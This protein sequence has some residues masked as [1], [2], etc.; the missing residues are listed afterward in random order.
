DEEKRFYSVR[1]FAWNLSQPGKRPDCVCVVRRHSLVVRGIELP[2][3][4]TE[5]VYRTYKKQQQSTDENRRLLKQTEAYF[6]QKISLLSGAKICS[7]NPIR[8]EQGIENTVLCEISAGQARELL[9]E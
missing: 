2:L 3:G 9:L 4:Y 8:T 5:Y 6:L 7:Q 1:F